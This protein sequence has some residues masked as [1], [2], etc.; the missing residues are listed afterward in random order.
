LGAGSIYVIYFKC[1][2]DNKQVTG[3]VAT[4][5]VPLVLVGYT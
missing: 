4:W 5:Q 2:F 1:L 3:A